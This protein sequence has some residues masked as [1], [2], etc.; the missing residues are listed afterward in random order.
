MRF[1]N[2]LIYFLFKYLVKLFEH[3]KYMIFYKILN[4]WN[5]NSFPNCS[6]SKIW[7]FLKLEYLENFTNFSNSKFFE[8]YK[9]DIFLISQIDNLKFFLNWT[10]FEFSKLKIFRIFL[11]WS[12]WNCPNWKIKKFRVFSQFRKSK[13]SNRCKN[14]KI[15]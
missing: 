14:K 7:C 1:F 3:S 4:S 12:S 6:I 2:F 15:K 5:F 13:F 8:F 11:I 10:F 9:L